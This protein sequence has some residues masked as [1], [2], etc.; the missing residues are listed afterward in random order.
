MDINKSKTIEYY[1][2]Y[3]PCRCSNCRNY[4]KQ[5][6]EIYPEI[7]EYLETLGIDPLKPF[8]LVSLLDEK[9]N[10]IVYFDCIYIVYGKCDEEEIA[11]INNIDITLNKENHPD[12]LIEED[13][14]VIDFG[15][16]KLKNNTRFFLYGGHLSYEEKVDTVNHV[17]I[18]YDP[19][20]LIAMHCP[21]DEYMLEAKLIVDSLENKGFW[22]LQKEVYYIFKKMFDEKVSKKICRKI[23]YD[24]IS[25]LEFNHFYNFLKENNTLQNIEIIGDFTMKLTIHEGFVITKKDRNTF[26]NGKYYYDIE[27]QDIVDCYCDFVE[28]QDIIYI[29]YKRPRFSV[30]KRLRYFKEVPKNKFNLENYINKNNI[31][32]I[33]DNKKI[34]YCRTLLEKPIDEIIEMLFEEKINSITGRIFYLTTKDKI[35]YIYQ[36]LNGSYSVNYERLVIADEYEREYTKKYGW[37]ESD[38]GDIYCSFYGT[39]EEA[40]N[41]IKNEIKDYIE[42]Y[43]D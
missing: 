4:Y 12:T 18:K 1:D 2:N 5:I 39:E 3:N 35:I 17:L 10:E 36:N 30:F 29:Q 42:Y 40:Y 25:D 32:L 23:A 8:E 38:Y 16:I 9:T 7:C 31:D 34:I 33:F 11:T 41:N 37:W 13:H 28:N 6:K 19:I 24:I 43:K 15:P 21:K 26:I 22:K 20:G 27:D 14:F